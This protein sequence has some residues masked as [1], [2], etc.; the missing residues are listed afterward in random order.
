MSTADTDSLREHVLLAFAVE[1]SHDKATL[2]RYL[3]RY[4]Q[5]ATDLVDLL[6]EL[7]LSSEG[8]V[9]TTDDESAAQKAWDAFTAT[10]PRAE[11]PGLVKNPF[12]LFQGPAFVAL[13]TEL[14]IRRSILIALRDRIVIATSI[15]KPFLKRL[16]I[17]TRSTTEVLLEYLDQ[18]AIVAPGASYKSDGKPE[19]PAKIEFERLLI[20]S[21]VTSEEKDDIFISS[22]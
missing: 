13:A 5:Y 10:P 12:T 21:G 4:P 22:T 3:S 11:R 18:P 2:E 1:P 17:A 9:P 16:A 6:S 8:V 7:R 19:A 15:P 20:N 14:R